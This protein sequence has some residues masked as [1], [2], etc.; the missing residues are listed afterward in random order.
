MKKL[1]IDPNV[2]NGDLIISL[3]IMQG[4]LNPDTQTDFINHMLQARFLCP[5]IFD[6]APE[7]N[8]E[9][10]AVL[11]DDAKVMLSSLSNAKEEMYLVAYTDAK[12]A[13]EHKQAENQHTV[14][15]TYFDFCTMVLQENS[16]YAGFVINPFSENIVVSREIMLNINKHVRLK[17]EV[18]IPREENMPGGMPN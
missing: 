15:C 9:G 3:K 17:K 5:A 14:A 2:N 8:P 16:P 6:P 18:Q 13:R 12:E 7:I 10:V 4:N 11:G 1:F